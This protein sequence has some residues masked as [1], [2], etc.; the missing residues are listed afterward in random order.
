MQGM[1]MGRQWGETERNRQGP[2]GYTRSDERIREVICEQLT[3]QHGV[4]VADVSVDVSQGSVT[5][6]GTVPERQMKYAIEDIADNCWG[7]KDVENHIRVQSRSQHAGSQQGSSQSGSYGE[8]EG[9]SGSQGSRGATEASP[10][11]RGES[12]QSS[13]G[14]QGSH[15]GSSSSGS[16]TSGSASKS[17]GSNTRS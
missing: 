15:S 16:S 10:G 2:R 13:Q 4:E 9:R 5:L 14:G 3:Q 17:T 11:A 7:V 12:S 8:S 6:E 1:G